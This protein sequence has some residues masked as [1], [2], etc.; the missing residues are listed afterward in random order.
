ME[1]PI[2]YVDLEI[3][4]TLVPSRLLLLDD[5]MR[6]PFIRVGFLILSY[7]PRFSNS[8]LF[9]F[10]FV[11]VVKPLIL[12]QQYVILC[13]YCVFFNIKI[14][15]CYTQLSTYCC[16]IANFKTYFFYISITAKSLVAKLYFYCFKIPNFDI[17][18]MDWEVHLCHYLREPNNFE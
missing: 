1:L 17:I 11:F 2:I 13:Y 6:A 8:K 15:S 10:K 9:S 18:Y 16:K 14:I 5:S 7:V 3:W 4:E 12:E